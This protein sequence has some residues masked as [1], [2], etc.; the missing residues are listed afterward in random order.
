MFVKSTPGLAGFMF[1][2]EPCLY[3]WLVTAQHTLPQKGSSIRGKG[4]DGEMARGESSYLGDRQMSGLLLLVTQPD[5]PTPRGSPSRQA[6]T[7]S[8][9]GS[10]CINFAVGKVINPPLNTQWGDSAMH[11]LCPEMGTSKAASC[12]LHGDVL[13]A[14]DRAACLLLACTTT[15]T[16]SWAP[17]A[18]LTCPAGSSK[19]SLKHNSAKPSCT[20]SRT[21]SF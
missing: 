10:P 8:A 21:Y 18:K 3:N 11:C 12:C 5:N 9:P 2:S 6:E 16:A 7:C 14:Q 19:P 15:G 20:P 17:K 13:Y 1:K 4:G